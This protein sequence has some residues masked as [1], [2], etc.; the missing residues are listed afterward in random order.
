MMM[1]ECRNRLVKASR[2]DLC[3]LPAITRDRTQEHRKEEALRNEISRAAF[4]MDGFERRFINMQRMYEQ[5]VYHRGERKK[6]AI[7]IYTIRSS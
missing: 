5:R 7:N 4:V 6:K 1:I 2:G 3:G